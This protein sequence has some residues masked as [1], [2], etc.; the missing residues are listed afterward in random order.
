MARKDKY[1]SPGYMGNRKKS[2]RSY[3]K[4]T[5]TPKIRLLEWLP[6]KIKRE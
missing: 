3:Q 6:F 2:R 1:L 5:F 4:K